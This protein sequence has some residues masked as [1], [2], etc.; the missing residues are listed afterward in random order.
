MR[1][2]SGVPNPN[3]RMHKTYSVGCNNQQ[4]TKGVGMRT[5]WKLRDG[6]ITPAQILGITNNIA[7]V[8]MMIK[9]LYGMA[10]LQIWSDEKHT[11][12]K[13]HIGHGSH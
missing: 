5:K 9:T 2:L 1:R 6:I 8:L 13:R 3:D 7:T 12:T 4:I 10:M 11:V